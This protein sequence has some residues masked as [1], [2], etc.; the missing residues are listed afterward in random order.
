MN[1][2]V[3]LVRNARVE[4]L[5]SPLQIQVKPAIILRI[6]LKQRTGDIDC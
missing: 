3:G 6:G 4:L 1:A 5:C 2:N